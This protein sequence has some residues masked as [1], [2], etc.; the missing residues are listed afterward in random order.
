MPA[1][2]CSKIHDKIKNYKKLR[3]R[4]FGS[5]FSFNKIEGY[6][7][8]SM[9]LFF[10]CCCCCFFLLLLFFVLFFLILVFRGHRKRQGAFLVNVLIPYPLNKPKKQ[11]FSSVLRRNRMENLARYGL[12][13]DWMNIKGKLLKNTASKKLSKAINT[14]KFIWCQKVSLT[15]RRFDFVF[16][17]CVCRLSFMSTPF[18]IWKL[19]QAVYMKFLT[20]NLD[21]R[22]DYLG[23]NQ[24]LETRLSNQPHT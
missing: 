5:V 4:F 22:K 9:P 20:R 10:F 21:F 16:S 13:W 2:C 23:L 19:W 1:I 14:E 17:R 6:V 7:T 15:V 8:H 12:I 11:K 18:P 3:C 24:Y